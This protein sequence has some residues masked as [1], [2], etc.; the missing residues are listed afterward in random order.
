MIAWKKSSLVICA[1]AS[2]YMN[3]HETP[4]DS[5]IPFEIVDNYLTKPVTYKLSPISPSNPSISLSGTSAYNISNY[6]MSI[7]NQG[8]YKLVIICKFC[9]LRFWS[10]IFAVLAPC[11]FILAVVE[12]TFGSVCSVCWYQ[13]NR[14]P[15]RYREILASN[16]RCSCSYKIQI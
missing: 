2:W 3:S 10:A 9:E 16:Q 14:N 15:R 6:I 11:G 13:R 5:W 4:L 1:A 7:I 8:Q 12:M